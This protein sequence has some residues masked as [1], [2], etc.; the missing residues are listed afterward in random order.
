MS[1]VE[2]LDLS[3]NKISSLDA[4]L[5][6]LF[7]LKMLDVSNNSISTLEPFLARMQL[8]VFNISNN[9]LKPNFVALLQTENQQQPQLSQALESCLGLNQGHPQND[10]P[11]WFDNPM[12]QTYTP[13]GSKKDTIQNLLKEE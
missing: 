1:H 9:P 13:A 12:N 4:S 6:K 5:E 10:K 7:K 8:Q 11:K 2:I 3:N